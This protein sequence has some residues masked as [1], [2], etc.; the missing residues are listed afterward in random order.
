MPGWL[1]GTRSSENFGFSAVEL[2]LPVLVKLSSQEVRNWQRVF[3]KFLN[4]EAR[5][6]PASDGEAI[7][8]QSDSRLLSH[9]GIAAARLALE[10]GTLVSPES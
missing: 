5:Q 1:L 8:L 3:A 10:S 2:L 9:V 6:C 4:D 7:Y